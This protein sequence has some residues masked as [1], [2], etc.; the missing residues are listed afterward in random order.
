MMQFY[1]IPSS[2][3]YTV[4]FGQKQQLNNSSSLIVKILAKHEFIGGSEKCKSFS[5]LLFR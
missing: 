3:I 1:S 4:E 5:I 2:S